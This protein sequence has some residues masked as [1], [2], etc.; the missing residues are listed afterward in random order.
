MHHS[1][2]EQEL[3]HSAVTKAVKDGRLR[4]EPC[5]VCWALP[6]AAHHPRGYDEAHRLDVVWLCARCHERIHG[7]TIGP[8]ADVGFR[9][10]RT[11]AKMTIRQLE[12]RTGI[13][14]GRLS[15]IERGVAPTAEEASRILAALQ[16]TVVPKGDAP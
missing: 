9:E 5:V 10:M 15:I 14:R 3:A 1:P 4:S 13:N 8:L 16:V 7:R 11:A 12:T 6:T 2:T